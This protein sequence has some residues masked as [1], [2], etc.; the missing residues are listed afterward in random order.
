METPLTVREIIAQLERFDPEAIAYVGGFDEKGYCGLS[1]AE[2][3]AGEGQTRE[4]ETAP[5]Y[6]WGWQRVCGS[7]NLSGLISQITMQ[8]SRAFG[9]SCR[10]AAPHGTM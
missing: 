2:S 4:T 10:K 3:R 1:Y 7:Q 5:F 6:M 9:M 8:K